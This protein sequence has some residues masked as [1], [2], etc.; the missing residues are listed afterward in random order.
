MNSN[1]HKYHP[2]EDEQSVTIKIRVD[3]GCF[4]K[5]HSPV[6]YSLIDQAILDIPV[7][8]KRFEI[9]EHE[10]GPEIIAWMAIGTAGL[11]F[12]KSIFDLVTAII[13]ARAKGRE[14]GDRPNGKL[15]LIVRN[16]HRTDTSTEEFV[17][18]I[19]D[20]EVVSSKQVKAAIER[21]LQRRTK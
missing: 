14:R 17:M 18:E 3:T 19:Y 7:D 5:E 13:N 12:T 1:L 10:S 20:K 2:S 15:L 21:G 8:E 4:H 16:T 6:A 9:M 11:T